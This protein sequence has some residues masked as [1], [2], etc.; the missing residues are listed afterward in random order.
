MKKRI[1]SF[2][3]LFVFSFFISCT[4]N[5]EETKKTVYHIDLKQKSEPSEVEMFLSKIQIRLLPLETKEFMCFDGEASKVYIDDKS[6]FIVD[7][8]QN[9]IFRF[10]NEGTFIKHISRRGQG[11]E[12]YNT[13]FNIALSKGLIYG[14]DR[15]KIQIYDY[16]GNYIKTIPL[17]HEGRQIW[18]KEDGTVFIAGNYIQPYQIVVYKTDGTVL[19]F[20]PSNK[21]LLK[22]SVSQS[23]HYSIGE[24]NSCVYLTNYFDRNIY[25]LKDSVSILA[26]LDFGGMNIS[27][28]FFAGTAEEIE[29]RFSDYR[30]NDK[31][32]FKIDHLTI[33]DKWLIFTPSLFEPSV[34]YYNR[35]SNK[36]I[37]NKDFEEPYNLF[38]GKYNAPDG[39]I[40]ETKEFYRLVNAMEFKEM[41]EELAKQDLDYLSLYPFLKNVD[42]SKIDDNTNDWII[43]FKL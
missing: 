39:Y 10:N 31:A 9:S 33:T 21:E 17:K 29:A 5:E 11:P 6:I 35:Q 12:E 37:V 40:E 3:I 18:V 19:E 2:A 15:K 22:L 28:G 26:T 43:F 25:Q 1:F 42:V 24:Y 32:V 27:D 23:T 30:K 7:A 8:S 34:V 4:E 41:I 16:V 14:L 36:Y 20:S 13:L 38:F